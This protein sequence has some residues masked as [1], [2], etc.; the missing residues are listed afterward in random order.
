[1]PRRDPGERQRL[2]DERIA[3]LRDALA[4]AMSVL[5]PEQ[6]DAAMKLLE[7]RGATPSDSER[8]LPPNGGEEPPRGEPPPPR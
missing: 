5:D 6:R 7:E 4:R 2:N 3:N 1:M 8:R